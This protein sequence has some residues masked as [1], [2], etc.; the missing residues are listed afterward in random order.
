METIAENRTLVTKSLF[1]EAMSAAG[2]A[3]TS[4]LRAVLVLAV[5]WLALLGLTLWQGMPLASAFIEL[6]VIAA[7]GFWILAILPR[8][9]YRKAFLLLEKRSHGQMERTLTF[10][11]DQ[12][13]VVSGG[14]K[15]RFSYSEIVSWKETK[16]LLVL[17]CADKTGIMMDKQGFSKG[18]A[19]TVIH[20]LQEEA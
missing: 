5:L 7:V 12:F 14:E 2:K 13:F 15:L 10:F 17:T 11:P 1:F 8:G 6:A 16:H 20:K 4:G 9:Q 19:Q 18:D 3:K